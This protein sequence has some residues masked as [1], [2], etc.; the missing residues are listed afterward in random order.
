MAPYLVAATTYLA[1]RADGKMKTRA[2]TV[3]FAR[4]AVKNVKSDA[5]YL[6][7]FLVQPG[8]R[9]YLYASLRREML[10]FES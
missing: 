9:F 2:Y 3:C 10:L 6:Q 8:R 5:Q 1:V 4:A 7:F